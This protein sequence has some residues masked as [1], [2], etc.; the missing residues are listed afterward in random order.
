MK[1]V[2]RLIEGVTIVDISGRIVLGE[3]C[4][5]IRDLVSDLLSK[6]RM[7]ILFNLRGGRLHRQRGPGHDGKRVHER[8]EPGRT[9]KAAAS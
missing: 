9:V 7:T 8:E 2:S 5:A 1:T 6:G 3:E 4:A